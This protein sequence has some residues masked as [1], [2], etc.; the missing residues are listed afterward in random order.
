[1][2]NNI[3]ILV[4]CVVGC[5]KYIADNEY[6]VDEKTAKTLIDF[7]YA[8]NNQE[9]EEIG[10]SSVLTLDDLKAE[11]F[12]TLAIEAE[13]TYTNVKEMK[14]LF[15]TEEHKELVEKYLAEKVGE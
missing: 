1:M 12:K 11:D 6:E 5:K 15:A 9:S 7:G 2:I 8:K 14:E 13:V 3:Y 10:T 4:T